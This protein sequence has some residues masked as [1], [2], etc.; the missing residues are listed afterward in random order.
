MQRGVVNIHPAGS[1]LLK[2]DGLKSQKVCCALHTRQTSPAKLLNPAT[3]KQQMCHKCS[4]MNGISG[5]SDKAYIAGVELS[6]PT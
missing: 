6:Y 2:Q 3:P 1:V 4:A 5:R